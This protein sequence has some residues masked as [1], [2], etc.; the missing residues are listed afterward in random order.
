M[1][2][3]FLNNIELDAGLVD[4]SNSTGTSGYVL[5]STGT[6]TSWVDASTVIG[7]PYV[8]IG[9][10]QTITAAKT[11][12]A[13][14][15]V[16]AVS[17][18]GAGIHLIYSDTVPEIRIQAG[19][20]GSSAFSIYN[21]ATSPDSEQFF[22]N[23]TLGT[24]HL[25]NARG[26]LKLESSSGVV[27]TLEGTAATFA[28]DLTVSGGDIILGGTGRIQGI[29]SILVGTDAVNKNYVDNNFVADVDTLWAFDADGAGTMQS[30]TVGD[31]VWFEGYN[32]ITFSSGQGS[33][34]FDHQVS[35]TLDLTGVTAGSYYSSN[36]TVDAYGR[37]SA[38]SNGSLT[39]VTKFSN[40]FT[41][42]LNT[43]NNFL[44]NASGIY[45]IA[46]TIT[47]AN[48]GQSGAIIIN[49]TAAT[50]AGALP[51]YMLTPE[52]ATLD[53]VNTSG[54]VSIISYFVI[55]TD[56]VLCNYVG[57]FQ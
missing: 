18:D 24:S 53:W 8:T 45:S 31:N 30:V 54:A 26:A 6:A 56:K 16:G 25:G 32:G 39:T 27:L 44:L 49:N 43:N 28:G 37:I 4:G 15:N 9:T 40:I 41:L 57:N 3:K 55:A 42:N 36:I 21:T 35:A 17:T 13:D 48:I 29:D 52:G 11:F 38:A 50:T 22:I 34:V 14:V 46:M 51:S 33:G 12:T 19:E 47:S 5:S 7:G 2:G 20:N 10:A 1:A 23:N